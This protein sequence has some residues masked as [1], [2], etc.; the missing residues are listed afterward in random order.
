[1]VGL[2]H[3]LKRKRLVSQQQKTREQEQQPDDLLPKPGCES[4]STSMDDSTEHE[5]PWR[6]GK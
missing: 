5:E 6:A 3:F 4:V 2:L 1:M